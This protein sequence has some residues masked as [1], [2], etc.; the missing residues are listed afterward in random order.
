[1]SQRAAT[2]YGLFELF[3]FVTICAVAA[4]LSE[5]IGMISSLA[6]MLMTIA[7]AARL[8]F[9]TLACFGL[10]IAASGSPAGIG[11]ATDPGIALIV[12]TLTAMSLI[13]RFWQKRSSV[14][15]PANAVAGRDVEVIS[16]VV[17]RPAEGA[18]NQ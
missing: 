8:G 2:R 9:V 4:A 6:L 10:A 1:M 18:G 5:T 3:Q 17:E 16:H 11:R 13:F 7:L 12:V 15:L 14:V